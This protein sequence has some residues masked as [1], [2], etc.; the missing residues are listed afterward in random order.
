MIEEI[1]K[2][3]QVRYLFIKLSKKN[4]FDVVH[5]QNI[6]WVLANDFFYIML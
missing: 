6:F 3:L 2:L 5:A 4:Y 1:Y